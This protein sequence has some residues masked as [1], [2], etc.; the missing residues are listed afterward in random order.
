METIPKSLNFGAQ[1]NKFWCAPEL[2]LVRTKRENGAHHPSASSTRNKAPLRLQ[3]FH[4]SGLGGWGL[5]LHEVAAGAKAG[6]GGVSGDNVLR[7]VLFALFGGKLGHPLR[8]LA[9][10]ARGIPGAH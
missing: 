6:G 8:G 5:H 10:R 4:L 9:L 7:F 1:Q 3:D 2:A